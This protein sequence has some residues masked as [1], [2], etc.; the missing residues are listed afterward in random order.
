MNATL[1]DERQ[2]RRL[3]DVTLPVA[4]RTEEE[5][6]RL[7][8]AAAA[9]ME[10]PEDELTE[11]QGRLL[12]LL[13]I[14]IEEYENRAHPLPKTKPHKMLAYLLAEKNM[15]PSDLWAVLPKSRV[16]EILSGKR[17]ISKAQAKQIAELLRVPVDLFL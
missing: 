10:R 17:G 12:E 16:S 14:L 11:E 15:K 13:S 4:I 9:L 2:Y 3:L 6:R 8:S 1:L 5:H 7:L